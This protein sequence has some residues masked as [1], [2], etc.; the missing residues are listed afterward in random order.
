MFRG[1]NSDN[2]QMTTGSWE[3]KL[4]GGATRVATID[5]S[6]L[7]VHNDCS[8]HLCYHVEV[9][10]LYLFSK[11]L[12]TACIFVF[13]FCYIYSSLETFIYENETVSSHFCAIS[14]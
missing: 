10:I 12:A 13:F 6:V 11:Y 9:K 4:Q 14:L 1:C 3:R 7:F 2:R 5:L 8:L